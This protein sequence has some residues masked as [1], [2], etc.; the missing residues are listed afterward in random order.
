MKSIRLVLL[1][2]LLMTCT[3]S[4][5]FAEVGWIY[6]EI[7]P[8]YAA[9]AFPADFDEDGDLDIWAV[10][11]ED[12]A[13]YENNGY[14][15]FQQNMVYELWNYGYDGAVVDL[16]QDGDLDGL[17]GAWS[18]DEIAWFEND[19][20]ENFTYTPVGFS[21]GPREMDVVDLDEDG[22]LDIV[23][24]ASG[25][26]VETHAVYWF[27]NDGS[28]NFTSHVVDSLTGQYAMWERVIDMDGDGD[29]DI[30]VA[31]SWA[32]SIH[33]EENDGSENFTRH[34][35]T[36]FDYISHCF[37]TDFDQDGDVDLTVSSYSQDLL[38]WY[39]NDGNFNWTEYPIAIG[40]DGVNY[41]DISDIDNDGDLDLM[42]CAMLGDFC[43]WFENDGNMNFTEHVLPFY[44][45]Y[46]DWLYPVDMD[47]D[48]D[49]DYI[50]IPLFEDRIMWLENTM[51]S[52]Y[53]IELTLT[54]AVTPVQIPPGGG[55][56][57]FDFELQNTSTSESYVVDVW[58]D[59]TLPDGTIYP[60]LSRTGVPLGPSASILRTLTQFVPGSAMPG[61]Y[62]LN[63]HVRDNATWNVYVEA[64]IPFDKL[65]GDGAENH[66]MG[67]ALLGWEDPQMPAVAELPTEYDLLPAYPNPF[68]PTT[69]LR[70]DLPEAGQ[71][72]LA[73]YDSQ[74]R[75]V[76]NLIDRWCTAGTHE[77]VFS[78]KDLASGI[79]FARLV[80]G[81]IHKS[82]KLVLTK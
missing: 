59:I 31:C 29:L 3:M 37:A 68:N 16:D 64:S 23:V 71:V 46:P 2:M 82:Q 81:D 47:F 33:W 52:P 50:V 60:V 44:M 49:L 42:A 67:W 76:A 48:G 70:F 54:P 24:A 66:D 40:M 22:D 38:V 9:S 15:A 74:G 62:V 45:N 30:V 21:D 61:H 79:Y 35:L 8:W 28:Q 43:T 13:W 51:L 72:K 65:E 41:H 80:A 19:G 39:E 10:G 73:V 7:Y 75:Q 78:G 69:T 56:F 32:D 63:A 58:T 77:A 4:L 20:S 25:T 14:Q 26:S 55:S 6:H 18:G 36:Y 27:E 11:Y 57:D 17:A 12:I 53:S 5:A 1:S 34:A